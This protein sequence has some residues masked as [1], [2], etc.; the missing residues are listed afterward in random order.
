MANLVLRV[1]CLFWFEKHFFIYLYADPFSSF[2]EAIDELIQPPMLMNAM[3]MLLALSLCMTIAISTV[4]LF[5][6]NGFTADPCN[7]SNE[8]VD[9][10]LQHPFSKNA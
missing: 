6:F 10:L 7:S 2:N 9:E 4:Q 8:A 3:K 1:N 5:F